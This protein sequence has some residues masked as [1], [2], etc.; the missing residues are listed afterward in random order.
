MQMLFKKSKLAIQ[1]ALTGRQICPNLHQ[2][3]I[4]KSQLSQGTCENL[5][6]FINVFCQTCFSEK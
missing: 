4:C 3:F 6:I 2:L 5:N 1:L